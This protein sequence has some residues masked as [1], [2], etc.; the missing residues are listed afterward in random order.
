MLEPAAVCVRCR[1]AGVVE[2]CD[3]VMALAYSLGITRRRKPKATGTMP[4]P[5]CAPPDPAPEGTVRL[6]TPA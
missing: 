2:T 1:G 3:A 5:W 6:V 4:C